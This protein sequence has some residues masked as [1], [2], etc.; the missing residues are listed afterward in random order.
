MSLQVDEV[1]VVFPLLSNDQRVLLALSGV[2][3]H[4]IEHK[5]TATI[6][7]VLLVLV[8]RKPVV[9]EYRVGQIGCLLPVGDNVDASLSDLLSEGVK[10]LLRLL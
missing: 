9:W 8:R 4:W 5:E 2:S 3:P 6:G 10:L 1:A 7:E